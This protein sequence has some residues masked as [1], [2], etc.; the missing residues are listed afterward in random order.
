MF[1][2][3]SCERKEATAMNEKTYYYGVEGQEI[4]GPLNIEAIRAGIMAGRLPE[5]V[6]VA[7]SPT[8]PWSA[9]G[10][11]KGYKPIKKKSAD[12]TSPAEQKLKTVS[13]FI[14]CIGILFL[15]AGAFGVA[16]L[17]MS[18]L[19]KD[20]ELFMWA[21]FTIVNFATGVFILAFAEILVRLIQ[22]VEE[23]RKR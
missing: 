3:N 7:E 13:G 11:V 18:I 14:E 5:N 1:F 16:M 6:L 9:P 21:G 19:K 22:I 17:V 23:L 2:V 12:E 4:S 10:L 8:G 15:A 20:L